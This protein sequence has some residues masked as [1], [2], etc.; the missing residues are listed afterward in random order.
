MSIK[1]INW[2]YIRILFVSTGIIS[3]FQIHTQKIG[4][5]FP[6][7][8]SSVVLIIVPLM[9]LAVIAMNSKRLPRFWNPPCWEINP[10]SLSEPFQFFHVVSWQVIVSGIVGFVL[11]PWTGYSY[12]G[13]AVLSIVFGF[14]VLLGLYVSMRVFHNH[15]RDK[16]ISAKAVFFGYWQKLE[17]MK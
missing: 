8:F 7:I 3:G 14:S 15:F 16:N 4:F 6:W 11:L 12:A 1:A 10:L 13:Q 9:V 2:K 17:T 5:P